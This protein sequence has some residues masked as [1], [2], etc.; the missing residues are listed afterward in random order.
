[1][2]CVNLEF[3]KEMVDSFIRTMASESN[4]KFLRLITSQEIVK[5]N[6]SRTRG[7]GPRNNQTIRS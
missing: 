5:L 4:E 6:E 1:M 2:P 7:R 3:N